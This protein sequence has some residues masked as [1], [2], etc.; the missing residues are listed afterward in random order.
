MTKSI[1][2][3]YS[4]ADAMAELANL[5]QAYL[6]AWNYVKCEDTQKS[7]KALSKD[8]YKRN[9]KYKSRKISL[10]LLGGSSF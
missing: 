6:G 5:G 10:R 1:H 8:S 2:T 7:L 3:V 9:K 4:Q